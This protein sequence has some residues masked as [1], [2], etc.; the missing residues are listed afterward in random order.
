MKPTS[1]ALRWPYNPSQ[2]LGQWK[3][4]KMVEV[5]NAYKNGRYDQAWELRME[6]SVEK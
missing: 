3:R 1:F 6:K 4:Y 2:N 5:S